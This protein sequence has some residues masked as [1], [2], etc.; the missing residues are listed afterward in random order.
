MSGDDREK[1]ELQ[2]CP[3][4]C[5]FFNHPGC[6]SDKGL[7]NAVWDLLLKNDKIKEWNDKW[8]SY[9]DAWGAKFDPMTYVEE[10]ICSPDGKYA[11]YAVG[12]PKTA[13]EGLRI[14]ADWF[15]AVYDESGTN[16]AVQN[17]LRDWA[18]NYTTLESRVR[19]LEDERDEWK[20]RC[21]EEGAEVGR[22]FSEYKNLNARH[23]A[24]V[25]AVKDMD[26]DEI[27]FFT[28]PSHSQKVLK[29]KAA[30]AEVK[31]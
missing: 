15:D 10:N 26:M 12:M 13:P 5:F 30:L 24:L 1:Y 21:E 4:G 25:E 16:A 3:K 18:K 2:G 7:G 19:E 9:W 8:V 11:K 6:L 14:L 20:K 28:T 31:K 27:P 29:L 22:L 17:D 23:A